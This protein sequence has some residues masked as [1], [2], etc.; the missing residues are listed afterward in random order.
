[1]SN[2]E[3]LKT[4]I[5]AVIKANGRAEI[6]GSIMNQTLIAMV[7]SLGKGYQFIGVA[8]PEINPNTPDEKV[9]YLAMQAGTYTNFGN[10]TLTT[11]LTVLKW[12]GEWH[13]L[14]VFTT[15]TTP[16]FDSA[17]LIT[18]GAVYN[19]IKNDGGAYD[20]SA[21]FPT[22][23]EGGGNTYT[24]ANAIT[25]VP[26]NMRKGGM[27]IKFIDAT[28]N[29]YVKHTFLNP[30]TDGFTNVNNWQGIIESA[31]GFHTIGSAKNHQLASVGALVEEFGIK[32]VNELPTASAS[33]MNKIYSIP[34]A[35]P[36]AGKRRDEYFTVE[37]G[38]AP[39]YTDVKD[40]V[41][42][43][44]IPDNAL[45]A[46]VGEG[47]FIANDTTNNK[48]YYFVSVHAENEW[49]YEVTVE[50]VASGKIARMLD[51][52]Q[53]ASNGTAWVADYH[54]ADYTWESLSPDL[55]SLATKSEVAEV[56]HALELTA[57]DCENMT[58]IEYADLVELRDD[59]E[60]VPGKW[61]RI[62]DYHTTTAQEDT[63]SADHQFDVIVR[64][65]AVN[66]LNEN[67]FAAISNGDTY[68]SNAGA[69]LEA[70]ELKYCLDNDTE[71][72]AWADDTD[73]KGVIYWM[74]DEWGNE[75]PYDFKNI[76][77]KRYKITECETDSGLV[78]RYAHGGAFGVVCDT[79]VFFWCYT[80]SMIDNNNNRT[81][82]LSTQQEK[83]PSDENGFFLI[84]NN[85]IGKNRNNFVEVDSSS[86]SILNNIVFVTD[87]DICEIQDEEGTFYGY[88]DNIIGENCSDI[89]FSSSV[90][91]N[92]IDDR[93]QNCLF[94]D[95]VD[96]INL[97]SSCNQI[98]FGLYA[99]FERV[100]EMCGEI[101]FGNGSYG[102]SIGKGSTLITFGDLSSGNRI[103]EECN[104]L[105]FGGSCFRNRIGN[106]NSHHNFGQEC[107]DNEIA[108][109]C[110]SITFGDSCEYNLI[111][112]AST[113]ITL[114]DDCIR[115]SFDELCERITI[116]NN[117]QSNKFGKINR[118]LNIGNQCNFN[119]FSIACSSI[120]MGQD[121]QYN[122][123]EGDVDNITL[124]VGSLA[125]TFRNK[126]SSISLGFGAEY[127]IFEQGCKE[128]IYG[129]QG[130]YDSFFAN[131]VIEAGNQN[132]YIKCSASTTQNSPLRNITIAKGVNITNT[133]KT[134]THPT[135][136]D[137]YQTIYKPQGSQEIEV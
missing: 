133:W 115:N 34:T 11:G 65:D 120:T 121:G 16:T 8:T 127:N 29:K 50:E 125:N 27:S 1:M 106:E 47:K 10:I 21:H 87:T 44:A 62:V 26:V 13:A 59:G 85:R 124:G 77:F 6:T 33:T 81:D 24:L 37:T 129:A 30:T 130:S 117:C 111:G 32:C 100:G 114:G 31:A 36:V 7:N 80:F 78:D 75:C 90:K 67:A 97:G 52:S 43:T 91:R 113:I 18:S 122:L 95:G 63:Q 19:A 53:Y 126:C 110:Q 60:L 123:F 102:N 104:R 20:V 5:D 15:D 56:S 2:Y 79:S 103:G 135:A 108:D 112:L 89:T 107:N 41:T 61:Y 28:T 105:T 73:G 39:D 101:K 84:M 17:D 68:F 14:T 93:C 116:G 38:I 118:N 23:G 88:N 25:K 109:K 69:K 9:Y 35:H 12:D 137:T 46:Q 94:G 71:R 4:A 82:D 98:L 96:N 49:G 134:I 99:N 86:P 51:E 131:N 136:G 22:G 48:A 55:S 128:I 58:S 72:F 119:V 3:L 70:W 76:M 57:L 64:A 40:L 132:I 74:R 45:G 83:Y 42:V 66:K 54:Y 92:K